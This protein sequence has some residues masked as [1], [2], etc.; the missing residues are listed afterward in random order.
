MFSPHWFEL[1][2]NYLE[3]L[4]QIS[5]IYYSIMVAKVKLKKSEIWIFVLSGED[6]N[7]HELPHMR[8]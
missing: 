5:T 3:F 2:K 8:S 1:S 7:L 6:L 4:T